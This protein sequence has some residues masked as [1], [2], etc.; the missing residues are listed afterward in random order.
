MKNNSLISKGLPRSWECFL[1]LSGLILLLPLFILCALLVRLSSPGPV[2]FRQKRVGHKG[3]VFTLFKFRTMI[4]GPKDILITA[5][6][7]RRITQIGRILRKTKLDELP[8]IYNVLRGDMSFVGPRPEVIEYVDFSN[9]LWEKVL[10][11]RPGITDPV[12]LQLRNEEAV[13]AKVKDKE[14]FYREVVQPYKLSESIKYLETRSLK[15]DIRII[16]QTF[17]VIVFPQ[18]APPTK[19]EEV[20]LSYIE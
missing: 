17:R 19:I 6:G 11:V 14:T 5:D 12:T 4:E 1:A 20:Q 3:K 10:S 13:L 7:D 18:T 2:F 8:E 15:K 16:I 9:S